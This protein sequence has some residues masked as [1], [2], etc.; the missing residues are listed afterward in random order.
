MARCSNWLDVCGRIKPAICWCSGSGVGVAHSTRKRRSRRTRNEAGRLPRHE[1]PRQETRKRM[2]PLVRKKPELARSR[3]EEHTSELQ[4][5]MR[6]SYA[7]LCL[8]TQKNL[9]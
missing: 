7:V 1:T 5:L 2:G 9:Q 8:K 6:T 3:S 4:S